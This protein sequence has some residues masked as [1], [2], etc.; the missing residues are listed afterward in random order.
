M[1]FKIHRLG[2]GFGAQNLPTPWFG[3]LASSQGSSVKPFWQDPPHDQSGI[4]SDLDVYW[5]LPESG[6]E[7]FKSRKKNKDG[8]CLLV[9]ASVG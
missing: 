2:F 7:W 3:S 9:M 5:R 6:D 4:N 8:L 1:F